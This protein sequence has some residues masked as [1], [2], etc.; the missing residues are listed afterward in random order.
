MS[1]FFPIMVVKLDLGS[2]EINMIFLILLIFLQIWLVDILENFWF[3]KLGKGQNYKNQNVEIQKE[4][5]KKFKGSEH[6]KCL[7]SSSLLRHQNIK[8]CL[9][10]SSQH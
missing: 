8:K 1:I 9:F 2:S 7:F 3:L 5:R 10:S 4:H 6:Q